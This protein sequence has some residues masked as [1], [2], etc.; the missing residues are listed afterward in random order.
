VWA[1][2]VVPSVGRER[3]ITAVTFDRNTN[4]RRLPMSRQ[5]AFFAGI[6]QLAR[7]SCAGRFA[8]PVA[9]FSHRPLRKRTKQQRHLENDLNGKEQ[10][11]DRADPSHRKKSVAA[12]LRHRDALGV[13]DL[14]SGCVN[15]LGSAQQ[16]LSHK[17][18]SNGDGIAL[19]SVSAVTTPADLEQIV[20]FFRFFLRQV[21]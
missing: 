16:L 18:R 6:S 17:R 8:W 12:K 14:A 4:A 5:R 2:T 7:T 19:R 15:R 21:H 9:F 11:R 10:D 1:V 20:H 13:N 3:Q